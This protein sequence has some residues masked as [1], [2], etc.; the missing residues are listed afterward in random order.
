M[1]AFADRRK[2]FEN[3]KAQIQQIVKAGAQAARE[4]AAVTLAQVKKAM[5]IIK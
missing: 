1:K 5:K 3:D 4:S 2:V